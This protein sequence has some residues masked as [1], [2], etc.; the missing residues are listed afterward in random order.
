VQNVLREVRDDGTVID[1]PF[2]G[3]LTIKHDVTAAWTESTSALQ[4]SWV[5]QEVRRILGA[6]FTDDGLER[7][8]ELAKSALIPDED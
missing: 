7:F 8:D 6:C 5:G 4:P 2:E 3:W 1:H